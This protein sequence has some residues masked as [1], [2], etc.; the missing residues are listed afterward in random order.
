MGEQQR[1]ARA[2]DGCQ[3]VSEVRFTRKRGQASFGEA[4]PAVCATRCARHANM[5]RVRAAWRAPRIMATAAPRSHAL[6]QLA[7][8]SRRARLL[9]AQN[10][11][12]LSVQPSSYSTWQLRSSCAKRTSAHRTADSARTVKCRTPQ[13]DVAPH[14]GRSR[15]STE[16]VPCPKLS[17]GTPDRSFHHRCV[18]RIT[19][20]ASC[21]PRL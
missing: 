5:Y 9:C 3:R 20:F 1:T 8:P 4:E 19:L 11:C 12:S 13:R 7:K 16:K 14:N 15:G 18:C 10:V 2:R 17:P 21:S 6:G